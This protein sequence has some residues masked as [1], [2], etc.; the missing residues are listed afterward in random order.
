METKLSGHFQDGKRFL[1]PFSRIENMRFSSWKDHRMPEMLW[2]VLAIGNWK[3]EKALEF[4][5]YVGGYIEKNHECFDITLSG[6][7]S[8]P[9]EKRTEFIAYILNWS[10]ETK[11]LL[12]SM[13][14][15]P[16]LPART[17]WETALSNEKL[18]LD[19]AASDLATGVKEVMWHQSEAATDCRWI[20]HLAMIL[21]QKISFSSSIKDIH[22]TLKGIIE[23]PNYG[24]LTRIRPSIRAGEI[25]TPFGKTEDF[26]W[27]EHFWEVCYKNTP[28][29]PEKTK[30]QLPYKPEEWDARKKHYSIE[31]I[32]VRKS[33]ITHA[34][35]VTKTTAIDS[36][37]EGS[38]GFALYGQSLI[39]EITIHN[40][41]FSIAGRLLLRSLVETYITFAYLAK[42]NDLPTWEAYRQH[43]S[44][45][46]KLVY[47]K[48]QELKKT[49]KW[50]DPEIAEKIANEDKWSEFVPIN[51]GHW[52]DSNLRILSET[53]GLK[54]IYDE[55]YTWL[56][57]YIHANWAAVRETVYQTCL[58]PL[59]RLHRIPSFATP[60]M[61]DITEDAIE[62]GN[63][64]LDLLNSL[65]PK[66]TDRI[67][68]FSV[69]KQKTTI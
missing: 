50:I 1:P 69:P 26:T 15:F 22:E 36:C 38:F 63:N 48:F 57:G 54:E 31:A 55:Y 11:G 17:E 47:L 34:L 59:H 41:N 51:V 62:I 65:Y 32:R 18:D 3:R 58:N 10:P 37:F 64:I 61:P 23:Y 42:K 13:L 40:L 49:P 30:I 45:Q 6:I 24:D 67:K 27:A 5:R 12:S 7:A 66:Y 28:C 53:A 33:L 35:N 29:I 39:D 68:F 8:L 44:G 56:S 9:L 16:N 46:A 21:A 52:D 25:G 60:N 4:F 2:A 14:L 19:K 20:K 43:G